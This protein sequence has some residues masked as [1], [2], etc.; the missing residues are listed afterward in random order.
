MAEK[1]RPVDDVHDS[2][3]VPVDS[4]DPSEYN[5]RTMAP[6]RMRN[7]K[8]ALTEFGWVTALTVNIRREKLGFDADQEG[9]QVMVG[10]HQRQRA[11]RELGMTEIPVFFI[12]VDPD[13][14]KALNVALNNPELSGQWEAKG[15]GKILQELGESD[16]AMLEATGFSEQ[17][18]QQHLKALSEP[19]PDPTY[20]LTPKMSEHYDYVVILVKNDVDWANLQTI[21]ELEKGQNY[22]KDTAAGVGLCRVIEF[23]KF[24]ALWQKQGGIKHE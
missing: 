21:M 13:K 15:L 3:W 8:R 11:A 2:Q 24:S 1:K 12:E 23:E 18:I 19:E 22:K 10:G 5:P 4:V 17:Q 16:K 9:R 6:A 20:P 7:L 14:E